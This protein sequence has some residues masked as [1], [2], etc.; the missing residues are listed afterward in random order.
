MKRVIQLQLLLPVL[1]LALITVFM[2]SRPAFPETTLNDNVKVVG[3]VSLDSENSGVDFAD[4]SRQS[5]AAAPP[6]SQILPA[7]KRFKLVMHEQAVLDRETGLVWQR[8]PFFQTFDWVG[9]KQ[10]CYQLLIDHCGGWR[11]PTVVELRTLID[12]SHKPALPDGNPFGNIQNSY[13]WSSTAN[14]EFSGKVDL[15]DF[16]SGY[17]DYRDQTDTNWYVIAVHSGW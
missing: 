8:Y 6:W 10:F 1:F 17:V 2:T 3:T 4:G 13:Y 14:A 15:V 12:E 16:T 7:D 11:L 5:T 9:A